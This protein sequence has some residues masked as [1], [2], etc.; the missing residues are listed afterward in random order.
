MFWLV[1]EFL[2]MTTVSE[3]ECLQ[4]KLEFAA[5]KIWVELEF[6]QTKTFSAQEFLQMKLV[7]M[8]LLL[9]VEALLLLAWMQSLHLQKHLSQ[10]LEPLN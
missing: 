6:S 9:L 2:Q 4:M 7:Q 1:L 10:H 8:D 3:Q 5:L